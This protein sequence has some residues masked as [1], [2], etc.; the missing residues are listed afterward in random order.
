[1][2][3]PTIVRIVGVAGYLELFPGMVLASAVFGVESEPLVGLLALLAFGGLLVSL[4]AARAH[5]RVVTLSPG[6]IPGSAS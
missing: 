3:P 5:D 2:L 1:M 6:G 4:A